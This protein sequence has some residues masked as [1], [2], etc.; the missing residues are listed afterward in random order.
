MKPS[1]LN[2]IS[3]FTLA[4]ALSICSRCK[5][6]PSGT[7]ISNLDLMRGDLLLCSGEDFGTATLG[8]S[9]KASVRETFG[10]A[11]ALLHS[12]EY[13]EAEKVFVRVIDA[14]PECAMAYWGVA[15]S[16]YHALWAPPTEEDLARCYEILEV[17]NRLKATP[18]EA[19]YLRAITA[20]YTD[21]E[22]LDHGTRSLKFEKAM[23][24]LYKEHPEDKEA[25]I[26]YCLALRATADPMDKTYANQRKAGE[27]LMDL[28]PDY[29]DHPGVAHYIIHNYDYPELAEQA[30]NAA[31]EYSQIASS[32]AHAAHMPSHIYTR[33][34][35]W[36]ESIN[37]NISS[38][39][40]AVCYQQ[41][42]GETDHW[43][44][45]MHALDYIVYAH[46]QMAEDEK[47]RKYLDYTMGVS[48]TFP[49]TTMK[50]VYAFAAIPV[51]YVLERKDWEA[52]ASL[53]PH[54][55]HF[56]WAEFPWQKGIIHFARA[57]GAAHT[58]DISAAKQDLK[59]LRK[60]EL[61]LKDVGD[62][63]KA[64][65]VSIQI[66]SAEAW[67]LYAEGDHENALATM[68][69]AVDLED[70]TEKMAVTPGEVLPSRELLGDMLL[71]LDKPT[72]ALATYETNLERT[73]E[74]FNSIYGAARAA[75]SAGEHAK[76]EDYYE[77]LLDLV[78]ETEE[79]RPQVVEALQYLKI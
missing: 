41:N 50:A 7:D 48:G 79:P 3:I 17:A 22:I 9:C 1:L 26:L 78:G 44:E 70:R 15:M 53:E 8:V 65:Q 49:G 77:R 40:A 12:F 43:D 4:I 51:R 52:A 57:L 30:L 54:H 34:G 38:T 42:L 59:E 27:I 13:E 21:W 69:D 23:E 63:Y 2:V 20:F 39:D 47:A 10:L 74:R 60:L 5:N 6:A 14:D 19:D 45:E 73:P 56:E 64:N 11:I 28:F 37:S 62:L 75:Q 31:R 67:I 71:E 35:L 72:K 16:N 55:N 18:R 29:P 76:A 32:S 66:K 58:G 46:L 25:T 68:R 33:L 36:D 61:Q 24:R